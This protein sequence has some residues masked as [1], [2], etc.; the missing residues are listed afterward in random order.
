MSVF[1]KICGVAQAEDVAAVAALAPDAMGF[2]LWD[3][4]PRG[5]TED[6]VAA[7]TTDWPADGPLRVGVFVDDPV[8]QLVSR[9]RLAGLD[10][11]QLHRMPSGEEWKALRDAWEG[12]LWLAVNAE[13]VDRF[14]VEA[15][16]PSPDR[17]VLDSGTSD[18]P[19]G[20]GKTGSWSVAR[21]WREALSMPVMLA[22]G[23]SPENV[24]GAI[25][26]VCP[27]GVDTSSGVER[28]PGE[29]DLDK[30]RQ[31]IEESRNA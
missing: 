2:I 7:W 22:G 4:S 23:L 18:M 6:H 5:V 24:A 28:V 15:L 3:R 1:V 10:V 30:V 8:E 13:R 25:A 21:E 29:K 9:A 16:D 31:F 26:A 11:I 17:I 12:G 19:G 14:A 27:A 20:T